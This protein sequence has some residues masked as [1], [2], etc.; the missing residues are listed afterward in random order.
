MR[1]AADTAQRFTE[2]DG[3]RADTDMTDI[4]K[5]WIDRWGSPVRIEDRLHNVTLLQR[6]ATSPTPA[7]VTRVQN[8]TGQ[9]LLA[10]YDP[11]TAQPLTVTDSLRDATTRY[12]WDSKWNSITKVIPPGGRPLQDH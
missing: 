4:W 12:I 10:S 8:P 9:V 3:P 5:Y 11:A 7:L 2:L 6:D 1:T